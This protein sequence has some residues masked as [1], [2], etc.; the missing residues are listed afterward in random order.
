MMRNR[1][2]IGPTSNLRTLVDKAIQNYYLK[3]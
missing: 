1:D 3:L 2:V